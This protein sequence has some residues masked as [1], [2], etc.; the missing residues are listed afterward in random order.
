MYKPVRQIIDMEAGGRSYEKK[1][2]DHS[3]CEDEDDDYEDIRVK[4]GGKFCW[5]TSFF[6]TL[7]AFLLAAFVVYIIYMRDER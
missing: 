3:D 1:F 7:I 6:F 2:S 4:K 5:L